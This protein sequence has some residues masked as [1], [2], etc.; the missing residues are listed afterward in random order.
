MTSYWKLFSEVKWVGVKEVDTVPLGDCENVSNLLYY[1]HFT[2]RVTLEHLQ[3]IR[4]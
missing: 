3:V 1:V 2:S 4:Q